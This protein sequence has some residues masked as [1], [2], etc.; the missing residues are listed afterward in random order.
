MTE[1][2]THSRNHKPHIST[3]EEFHRHDSG[4]IYA[5]DFNT[6]GC[7]EGQ[8]IERIINSMNFDRELEKSYKKR[9][10]RKSE[11]E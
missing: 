7:A 5:I 3:R 1:T 4:I 9:E 10:M 8:H 6:G 2:K 11:E